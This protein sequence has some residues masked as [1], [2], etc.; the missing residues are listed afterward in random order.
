MNPIHNYQW[1]THKHTC[2][3]LELMHLC[4]EKSDLKITLELKRTKFGTSKNVGKQ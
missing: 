1:F 2:L 4:G 3:D